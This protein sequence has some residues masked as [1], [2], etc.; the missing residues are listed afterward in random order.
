MG[1][2]THAVPNLAGFTEFVYAAAQSP[3]GLPI[4]LAALPDDSPYLNYAFCAALEIVWR[5]IALVAPHMY[6]LAVYN[7]GMD[8]LINYT[9]DQPGQAYFATLRGSAPDGYGINNF[10][11]GVVTAASDVATAT[12]LTAPEFMTS[13]TL[14]N[15][16]NLKTPFGLA[17]LSIAQSMGTLWGIS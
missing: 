15:L 1:F 2:E 4:P 10:V 7:L 12:T 3:T 14:A 17:Y 8:N 6:L 5:R 16:Q 11:P 9:P 13:L